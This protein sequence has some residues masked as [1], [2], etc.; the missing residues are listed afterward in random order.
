MPVKKRT[1]LTAV[2]ILVSLLLTVAVTQFV[3]LGQA[4]PFRYRVEKEGDV[5]T[6][7]GTLPPT[8]LILSPENNTAYASHT[9]S[10]TLNVSMPQ[11]NNVSLSINEIYY[12]ASWLSDGSGLRK[13]QAKQGS[14]N[15]T[16]IPE[17]P[18]WLWVYAGAKGFGYYTRNETNRVS[19]TFTW[20][21]VDYIPITG[22][23]FVKF[24]IDTAAPSILS[25][26]V[27]N[28]TYSTSNVTLSVIVNEPVSQVIYG[29]DGRGNVTAAG[30][31]TLTDLPNGEYKLTVCVKDLAGNIGNW[32]TV[33]FSVDAPEPFSVVPVAAASV[34]SA[35]SV[36]VGLLVYFRKVRKKH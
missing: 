26:S 23:S 21:Y 18:R 13:N 30:N 34:A 19:L 6:P 32:E 1:L 22:S 14:I 28:K 29:L 9:V 7:E 35:A 10:L 4:N 12:M 5:P 25:L 24:I 3:N 27:E 8:V 20:Y 36:G 31:T 15:L 33:Y 2:F 16:D 11:S 17:G